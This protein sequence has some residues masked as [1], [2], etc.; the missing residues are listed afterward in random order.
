MSDSEFVR[1]T[2]ET[3][4]VRVTP[5]GAEAMAAPGGLFGLLGV[6]RSDICA[7]DVQGY[8]PS[9]DLHFGEEG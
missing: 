1:Q 6:L 7:R 4:G 3:Q 2:I 5:E 9:A 8:V